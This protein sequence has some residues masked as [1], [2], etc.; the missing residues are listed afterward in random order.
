MMLGLSPVQVP[1]KCPEAT[2]RHRDYLIGYPCGQD[3]IPPLIISESGNLASFIANGF[4]STTLFVPY[5]SST[6]L[7]EEFSLRNEQQSLG[8][9][10]VIHRRLC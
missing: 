4:C 10:G 7:I 3:I 9:L 8:A 6:R 2:Q 5:F 1:T